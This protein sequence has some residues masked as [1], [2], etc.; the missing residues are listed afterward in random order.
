[1]LAEALPRAADL[2]AV[3]AG[4]TVLVEVCGQSH[5]GGGVCRNNDLEKL[6]I[7]VR[8]RHGGMAQLRQPEGGAPL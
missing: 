4:F 3:A 7:T 1:M 8:E 2:P 6:L 5:G